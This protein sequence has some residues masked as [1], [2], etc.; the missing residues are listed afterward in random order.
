[1]AQYS[2]RPD[3][4]DSSE[5]KVSLASEP[6]G[7]V[8]G[9][10][11]F[12]GVPPFHRVKGVPAKN[13]IKKFV[14]SSA[15]KSLFPGSPWI[16]HV[17]ILL[18][19]VV[20]LLIFQDDLA[21]KY[22]IST[23]MPVDIK[24]MVERAKSTRPSHATPSFEIEPRFEQQAKGPA[25]PIPDEEL[26]SE[27][28]ADKPLPTP[29]TGPL[30][31]AG[32]TP[33]ALEVWVFCQA[34]SSSL[35]LSPFSLE[36]FL[37]ALVYADLPNPILEAVHMSFFGLVI[38]ERRTAGKVGL[39]KA[40]SVINF[41]SVFGNEVE[42]SSSPSFPDPLAS[43]RSG[44]LIDVE[45]D[46]D[47][48]AQLELL[49]KTK[50]FDMPANMP[51]WS[52]LFSFLA[53][54]ALTA[55]DRR[56]SNFVRALAKF[57]VNVNKANAKAYLLLSLE[58]RASI[59]HFLLRFME[60]LP[61]IR[62]ATDGLLE[63][64]IEAKKNR[65]QLEA[66]KNKLSREIFDLERELTTISNTEGVDIKEIK[67]METRIRKMKSD[68][69]TMEK[70]AE[71]LL[72]EEFKSSV[73]RISSL[74]MDRDFLRYWWLDGHLVHTSVDTGTQ[75]ILI[76]DPKTMKWSYYDDMR[77][78]RRLV[79]CLNPKG[80]REL[81]LSHAISSRLARMSAHIKESEALV[82]TPTEEI[83][84]SEL[85]KES[86]EMP[87]QGEDDEEEMVVVPRRRGR[88][89]KIQQEPVEPVPAFLKYKNALGRK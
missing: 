28:P 59:L 32:L 66:D 22:G 61:S 25:Y 4:S 27:M 49:L 6:Y 63:K 34:F 21:A 45:I 44:Q 39:Q 29:F 86:E 31:E 9:E 37:E 7:T 79:E 85:A 30:A 26:L 23:E 76:E 20:N 38:K 17:L 16:L 8:I 87:A 56:F 41:T 1:M 78:I 81:R 36:H 52:I 35:K 57:D 53:D 12:V 67:K 71:S 54:M 72:K 75:M 48:N 65:R 15:S 42:T 18:S 74:G 80:I 11:S 62:Q 46:E 89:P 69:A 50:W 43:P 51:W 70:K 24:E 58:Q 55:E 83:N 3:G 73:I 60:A 88:R 77:E 13:N 47:P 64:A 14:K 19:C 10:A 68:E 82:E 33:I 5:Y 84:P 2:I 40:L